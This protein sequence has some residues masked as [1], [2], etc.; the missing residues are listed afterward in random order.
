MGGKKRRG[1]DAVCYSAEKHRWPAKTDGLLRSDTG[2]F[3]FAL[4]NLLRLDVG[5]PLFSLWIFDA[6]TTEITSADHPHSQ[7]CHDC[8]KA[9]HIALSWAIHDDTHRSRRRHHLVTTTPLLS[10]FCH[11]YPCT[12][13]RCCEP[14]TL[15]CLHSLKPRCCTAVPGLVRRL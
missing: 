13:E 3:F 9:D 5:A 1:R 8:P 15:L 4:R 6:H 10:Y 12:L 11:R 2:S 14:S 7:F